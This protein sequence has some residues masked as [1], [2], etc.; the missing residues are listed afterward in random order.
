MFNISLLGKKKIVAF[1][2]FHGVNTPDV[3]NFKLPARNVAMDELELGR[4]ERYLAIIWYS[5]RAG[6]IGRKQSQERG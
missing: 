6:T 1:T 5:H 3:T 4:D 2:N